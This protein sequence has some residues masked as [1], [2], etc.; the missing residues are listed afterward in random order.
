MGQ[1]FFD[2]KPFMKFQNCNFFFVTDARTYIH[3]YTHTD[4]PKAICPFN[5]I[6]VGGIKKCSML[7]VSIQDEQ[8]L[9]TTTAFSLCSLLS[10]LVTNFSLLTV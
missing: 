7:T 3:T 6:K 4:K 1:L 2:D 8:Y 5:F 10:L 9:F